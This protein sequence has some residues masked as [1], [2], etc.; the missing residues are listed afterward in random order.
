[1]LTYDVK[2]TECELYAIK[3]ALEAHQPK[4]TTDKERDALTYKIQS[5]LDE[6]EIQNEMLDHFFF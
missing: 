6:L 3:D 4:G 5:A 2:L 1:M